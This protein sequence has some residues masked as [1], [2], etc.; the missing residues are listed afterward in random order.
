MR[1]LWDTLLHELEDVAQD[2]FQH[3]RAFLEKIG[4]VCP[5]GAMSTRYVVGNVAQADLDQDPDSRDTA[6]R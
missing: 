5:K 6:P 2:L 1:R 3:V 4:N